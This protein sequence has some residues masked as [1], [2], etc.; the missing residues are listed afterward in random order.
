VSAVLRNIGRVGRLRWLTGRRSPEES[1]DV[2]EAVSGKPLLALAQTAQPWSQVRFWL[3]DLASEISAAGKDET[4]PSE[5]ALDR[6]WI[7]GDGRAKLLDFPAPG[8]PTGSAGIPAGAFARLPHAGRDASAP[9]PDRFLGNVATAA[10][11]GLAYGNAPSN[12][13]PSPLPLHARNFLNSLPQLLNADAVIAAL[14][15]LLQRVAEVSRLRRAAIVAGCLSFPLFACLCTVF[16]T[17]F[18]EQWNRKNP[19][20]MDLNMLLQERAGMNSRWLKNQPR[21]TD[22]QFA[23]YIAH[24]YRSVVTNEPS[25]SSAF[26]LAMIKGESRRFAEQSVAENPAP[27]EKE[28]AEADAALKWHRTSAESANFIKQPWFPLMVITVSLAIY[29]G[30][31]ALIAAV[32]FRGGLVVLIAGVTFVRHDGARASRLR[33]LWRGLVAWSPMLLLLVLFGL[34]KAWLGTFNAALVA[35]LVAFGLAVLSV[36]LPQ[37]GLPD[38]LAGTWPVPR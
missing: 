34:L 33:V 18:L 1:W 29:V 7:T 20:L 13:A 24:H 10:L 4:M 8:L 30:I 15:P 26:A 32:L 27:T 5:L 31:P 28:I 14:R 12:Q 6:V 17:S 11:G 38:H 37:R 3:Y 16:G 25:W 23:I 9:S 2:F 19:G 35:A 21:T 22:R 36:G